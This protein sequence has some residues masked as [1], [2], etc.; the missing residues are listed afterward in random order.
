MFNIFLDIA[1]STLLSFLMTFLISSGS[2][3]IT[4]WANGEK[5]Q[6][7]NAILGG[8]AILILNGILIHAFYQYRTAN[9]VPPPTTQIIQIYPHPKKPP[10]YQ[11]KGNTFA[12]RV[13]VCAKTGKTESGK[14]EYC[15]KIDAVFKKSEEL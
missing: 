7:N 6:K 5:E 4:L 1:I 12:F 11:K 8:F 13:W 14:T 9:H 2:I 15:T 10:I 3:F